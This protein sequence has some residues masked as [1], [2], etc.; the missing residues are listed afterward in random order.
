MY[1]TTFKGLNVYFSLL[2]LFR[3]FSILNLIPPLLLIPG[4]HTG[5]YVR[6]E[7][8][9]LGDLLKHSHI[10]GHQA[11]LTEIMTFEIQKISVNKV[12]VNKFQLCTCKC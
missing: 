5:L 2:F 12:V 9:H 3:F 4:F 11:Y 10:G 1:K 8:G 7:G 6:G